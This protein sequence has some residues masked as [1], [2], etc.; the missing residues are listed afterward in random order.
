[1]IARKPYHKGFRRLT[2]DEAKE[3]LRAKQGKRPARYGLKRQKASLG[4]RKPLKPK[5]DRKLAEWSRKVR[6]RD[7]NQC[8]WPGGCQTGDTRIDAHHK[9]KRSQ[10]PDRKYD[11]DCGVALCR[12][13][14]QWTDDHHDQAVSIGLLDLTS[15]ELARKELR[16]A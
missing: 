4:Q 14:H 11:V 16:A 9:L 7:G 3:R 12:T 2:F 8:Q 13:H 1:M 10:R 6:E 5:V 15:Y